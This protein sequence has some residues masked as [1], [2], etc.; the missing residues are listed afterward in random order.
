M[1]WMPGW[2]PDESIAAAMR[3][4]SEDTPPEVRAEFQEAAWKEWEIRQKMES[5]EI[6]T[7]QEQK[8]LRK[9]QMVTKMLMRKAG[10]LRSINLKIQADLLWQ[11]D[12]AAR[13]QGMDRS[14]WIRSV[15]TAALS[16]HPGGHHTTQRSTSTEELLEKA[17]VID[18]RAREIV[19]DLLGRVQKLEAEMKLMKAPTDPFA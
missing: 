1:K 10:T 3:Q 11:I 8:A 15:C 17:E 4:F 14:N 6:L 13:D 18:E 2:T 7:A 12:N 19:R 16:G 9:W 5:A